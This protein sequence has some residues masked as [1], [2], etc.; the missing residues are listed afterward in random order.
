MNQNKKY[1]ITG[2]LISHYSVDFSFYAA[3]AFCGTL[4]GERKQIFRENA[5]EHI[6]NFFNEME[7]I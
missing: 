2:Y 5:Y 4:T 6:N 7:D 3:M 1:M